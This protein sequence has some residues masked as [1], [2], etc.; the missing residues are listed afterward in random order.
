[1][2]K[3]SVVDPDKLTN[4]YSEPPKGLVLLDTSWLIYR[5]WFAL[6]NLS[7]DLNGR[8]KRVGHIF[9]PIKVVSSVLKRYPN[10]A[11]VFCED[12]YPAKKHEL[13]SE[14]KAGRPER[15]FDVKKV[16]KFVTKLISNVPGVYF[17][18]SEDEEAD[19]VMATLAMRFQGENFIFSGDTDMLQLADQPNIIISRNLEDGEL[20]PWG[21]EYTKKKYGVDPLELLMYRAIRGDKS[22]NISGYTRFPTRVARYLARSYVDPEHLFSEK[23]CPIKND[24]TFE[25]YWNVIF[26]SSGILIRNFELMSLEP[27]SVILYKNEDIDFF[28]SA[29]SKYKFNS[30]KGLY[31]RVTE[32]YEQ[33]G[34][35][36]HP[37]E[38][39]AS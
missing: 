38:T 22:D 6:R 2:D 4:L 31:N 8:K 34:K 10:H 9:Y 7:V 25:K 16:S 18:V 3:T 5:G 24:K 15:E 29:V 35:I 33:R 21:S 30:L 36:S 19:S 14:Y 27:V 37:A 12:R 17:A 20:E 28:W 26:S 13:Y 11:V 39:E 1:M 23:A 32:A